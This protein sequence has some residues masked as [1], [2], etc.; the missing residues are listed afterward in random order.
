MINF[1]G[2]EPSAD[3]FGDGDQRQFVVIGPVTG[4]VVTRGSLESGFLCDEFDCGSDVLVDKTLDTWAFYYAGDFDPAT[5]DNHVADSDDSV[6]V[7]DN[8]AQGLTYTLVIST[9]EEG[10]GVQGTGARFWGLPDA[11]QAI[12]A[13]PLWVLI[14]MAAMVLSLVGLAVRRRS[15]HLDQQ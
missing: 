2:S 14:A 5:A 8:I 11:A 1:D 9:F 4:D 10:G 7:L 12:P 13:S 3:F 15:F 6:T